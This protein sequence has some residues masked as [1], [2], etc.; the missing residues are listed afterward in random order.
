MPLLNIRWRHSL[1]RQSNPN[2]SLLGI[3]SSEWKWENEFIRHGYD[4]EHKEYA[5]FAAVGRD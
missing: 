5:V 2:E 1:S 3:S 4:Y